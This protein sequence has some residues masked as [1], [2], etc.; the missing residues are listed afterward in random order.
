MGWTACVVSFSGS[1]E[2]MIS[3]IPSLARRRV[4][5]SMAACEGAKANDGKLDPAKRRLTRRIT[6]ARD[7]FPCLAV[8]GCTRGE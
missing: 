4:R 3:R 6:E 5:L 7:V 2:R 8:P 1:P